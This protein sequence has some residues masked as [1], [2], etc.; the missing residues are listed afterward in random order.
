MNQKLLGLVVA[1]FLLVIF[2]VSVSA[3]LLQAQVG[4][5]LENPDPGQKVFEMYCIGCHGEFGDGKGT[6]AYAMEI[7]P[8]NFIEGPYLYG[9]VGTVPSDQE[10]HDTIAYGRN[11][12]AMP[13][14]PLLTANERDAVIAYIKN[15]YAAG[16]PEDTGAAVAAVSDT[17]IQAFIDEVN[18]LPESAKLSIGNARIQSIMDGANPSCS[19]CHVIAAFGYAGETGPA[20]TGIG[21]RQDYNYVV[22]SIVNPGAVIAAACPTGPCTNIMFA[23]YSQNLSPAEVDAIARWL[24]SDQNN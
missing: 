20:L 21:S 7:A 18:N 17:E 11:N 13:A 22:E 12:G 15:F 5:P 24:T 16:W 8:R 10:L 9:L 6:A 2:G 3:S 4:E 14:F 23:T 19:T 1:V